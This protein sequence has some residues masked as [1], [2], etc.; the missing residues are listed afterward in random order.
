L[1]KDIAKRLAA[2]EKKSLKKNVWGGIKVMEIG[3][4]DVINN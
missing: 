1:D 4:S 3:E 2:F